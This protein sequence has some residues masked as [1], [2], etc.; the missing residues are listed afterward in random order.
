MHTPEQLTP[1]IGQEQ[2]LYF[3]TSSLDREGK[4]LWFVRE[5]N[6]CPNIF[7]QDLAEGRETQVTANAHGRLWQYQGFS[8]T[9]GRGLGVWSV[10]LDS[11]R[12]A[13]YFIQDQAIHCAEPDG[14]LHQLATLPDDETTAFIDVSACG[15]WLC[16]PTT[17][18]R[19]LLEPCTD[20]CAPGG[21]QAIDQRCQ[22]WGLSSFLRVYDTATG[23]LALCICV[24]RCWITHVQ[25]HP[26]DPNLILYNHE[27]PSQ[28]GTRRMWLWDGARHHC[29]RPAV[30]G[31]HA[32][33]WA[34]HEVWNASGNAVIYHGGY[35]DGPALIGRWERA[36]GA[37]REIA[38]PP[39]WKRY[40][41][42]QTSPVDDHIL[43]SDGYYQTPADATGSGR[44]LSLQTVDWE[45]GTI[46]WTPLCQHHSTWQ[47]QD[48]HP[49]PIFDATG[50]WIYFT[51]GTPAGNR[52]VF[53]VAATPAP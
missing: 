8:G 33:D 21:G 46:E 15:R 16:V 38:L 19:A 30:D 12:D 10:A 47:M 25:F 11:N 24:P 35:H 22:E 36:T 23:E 5:Q 43:V 13:L 49:H 52:A 3:T 31:R 42:F 41:H 14:S 34:C 48:D 44:W 17:D 29:L 4:S 2:L 7:R 50:A 28:C 18:H 6:G 1:G 53:R 37:I 9:P 26:T 39:E 32:E 45:N 40:G 27:W 51:G 20:G